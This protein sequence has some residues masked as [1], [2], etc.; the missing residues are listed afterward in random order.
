[1]I[2]VNEAFRGSATERRCYYVGGKPV[3]LW[4]NQATP[5][6]W[7]SS[8]LEAYATTEKWDL[9]FNALVLSSMLDSAQQ[10]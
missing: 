6:G 7:S 5:F 3:E 8:D 2:M 9:L 10:S 1:M 4:E